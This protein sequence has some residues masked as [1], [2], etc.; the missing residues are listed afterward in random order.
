MLS[1]KSQFLRIQLLVTASLNEIKGLDAYLEE[2]SNGHAA[3]NETCNLRRDGMG[4]MEAG[5]VGLACR[6]TSHLKLIGPIRS[7]L[8]KGKSRKCEEVVDNG[9]APQV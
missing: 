5:G 7:T 2:T 4:E 9:A 1:L 6:V 3:G 8:V